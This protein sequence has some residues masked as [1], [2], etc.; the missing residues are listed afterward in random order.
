MLGNNVAW[1][2]ER[3]EFETFMRRVEECSKWAIRALESNDEE[4]S[5]GMWQNIFNRDDQEEF[6]PTIVED[7]VKELAAARN[8]GTIR[9]TSSGTLLT[10]SVPGVTSWASPDHRFYGMENEQTAKG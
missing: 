9:V 6:F 10:G 3:S 4:E 1:N 2:W 8:A 7:S 5:I